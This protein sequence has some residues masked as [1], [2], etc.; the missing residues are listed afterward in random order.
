[1][2]GAHP[3]ADAITG[4]LAEEFK[5]VQNFSFQDKISYWSAYLEKNLEGRKKLV[6]WVA[7]QK[8]N[9]SAPI[10]PGEYNCTTFVET[11]AAL[12]RSQTPND[13]VKNILAIRYREGQPSYENR[14]H[15]P[16]ADWIPNNQKAKILTDITPQLASQVGIKAYV[17]QKQIDRGKW[18]SE[19]LEHNTVSRKIASLISKDWTTPTSA[20]VNYVQIAEI[21]KI[22]DQIPNGTVLNL[23][24]KD[25]GIHPGLITHQGFV[26]REKGHILLRHASIGG[27]IRTND[28]Y[29]YLHHLEKLQRRTKKWPLIGVN[30]NQINDS[31]SASS[32]LSDSM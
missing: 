27:L 17:E 18:L 8:V 20:Q 15:F 30:L 32:F 14:N 23:V 19:Q 12:A 13:I 4:P 28:L 26:I 24:H 11:V 1:M 31:T 7:D 6:S 10:I 5:H 25:D 21:K 9:D 3:Q 2:A 16:E 29:G 22:L